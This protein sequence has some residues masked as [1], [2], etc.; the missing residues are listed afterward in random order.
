MK[1]IHDE[2]MKVNKNC[3]QDG[4]CGKE[5]AKAKDMTDSLKGTLARKK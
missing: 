3:G 1:V 4:P 2:I 5:V